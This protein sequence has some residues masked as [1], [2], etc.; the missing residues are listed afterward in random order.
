MNQHYLWLVLVL[1]EEGRE[2]E[3]HKSVA[4]VNSSAYE[5]Y[6]KLCDH[7]SFVSQDCY[8]WTMPYSYYIHISLEDVTSRE[9][10]KVSNSSN[11]YRINANLSTLHYLNVYD[12][13]FT[14][15]IIYSQFTFEQ[16]R[17]EKYL[18]GQ[19]YITITQE[20]NCS[21]NSDGV[22]TF[23]FNYKDTKRVFNKTSTYSIDNVILFDG[24]PVYFVATLSVFLIDF[25][26]FPPCE[27]VFSHRLIFKSLGRRNQ[28]N[29]S[30]GFYQVKDSWNHID[31][32]YV[33]RGVARI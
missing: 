17:D 14:H 31:K 32:N 2:F 3:V 28:G 6:D 29:C 19:S 25:A 7:I 12:P 27:V 4:N 9:I 26:H 11:F 8:D 5:R 20:K 22:F 30:I 10:Y 16:L 21:K 15:G 18:V 24:V 33:I 13:R 1:N 23:Y